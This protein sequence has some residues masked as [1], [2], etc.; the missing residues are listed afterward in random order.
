MKSLVVT[1]IV[2]EIVFAEGAGVSWGGGCFRGLSWAA[3]VG[4]ALVFVCGSAVREGFDFYF[5]AV[6]C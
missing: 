4:R 3:Y 6:S 1:K 5:S 2:R